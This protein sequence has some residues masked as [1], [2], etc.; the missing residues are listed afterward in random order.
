MEADTRVNQ[1]P[2]PRHKMAQST[3]AAPMATSSV[4]GI[5][6]VSTVG[7]EP[8][9]QIEINILE[10]SDS[11]TEGASLES[12]GK[13]TCTELESDK[14]CVVREDTAT[15]KILEVKCPDI[16]RTEGRKSAPALSVDHQSQVKADNAIRMKRSSSYS[17]IHTR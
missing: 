6:S 1:P 7:Q 13:H 4:S 8:S 15:V 10:P 16:A 12:N 11:E 17:K 14:L 3:T 5:K 2:N 9:P